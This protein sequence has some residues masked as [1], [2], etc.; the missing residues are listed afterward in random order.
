MKLVNFIFLLLL[1]SVS[2]LPNAMRALNV[3]IFINACIKAN[4]MVFRRI[5][6]GDSRRRVI[7]QDRMAYAALAELLTFFLKSFLVEYLFRHYCL[8]E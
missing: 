6:C 4:V 5:I 7:H 8:E 3:F 1:S 2:F